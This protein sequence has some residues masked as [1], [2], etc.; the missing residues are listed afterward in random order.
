MEDRIIE[1]LL[2]ER[3]VKQ[4]RQSELLEKSVDDQVGMRKDINDMRQDISGLTAVVKESFES[5]KHNFDVL[6]EEVTKTR[7][8]D[9]RV[10][11][12]EKHLFKGSLRH[13]PRG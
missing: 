12:I 7:Q 1:R 13:E 8:L 9:E 4:D 3:L 10:T 11:R 2:S 6:T 5:I